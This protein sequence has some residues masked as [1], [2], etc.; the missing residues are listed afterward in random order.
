[1]ECKKR[2]RGGGLVRPV[3]WGITLFFPPAYIITPTN[4]LGH[5]C[6]GT[7]ISTHQITH[8]CIYHHTQ[9][10][11]VVHST[12][13]TCNVQVHAYQQ[14]KQQ[15]VAYIVTPSNTLRCS[16][17]PYVACACMYSGTCISSHQTTYCCAWRMCT[18]SFIE[19]YGT[20]VVQCGTIIDTCVVHAHQIV[21]PTVAVCLQPS[22]DLSQ[23]SLVSVWSN[24][25]VY[26]IRC[27]Y[28][29]QCTADAIMYHAC[30]HTV[31]Y[32][33]GATLPVSK[34]T[35]PQERHGYAVVQS[36]VSSSQSICRGVTH[37]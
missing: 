15:N 30:M 14:T 25:S 7:C 11:T 27:K 8:C 35:L 17:M 29:I 23:L 31:L 1:M 2:N 24:A 22:D 6:T 34:A 3:V 4:T 20:S 9:Q 36:V 13:H 32:H 19:E 5:K 18:R 16:T 21:F 28:T 10:H 26:T 12:S 37:I 33:A